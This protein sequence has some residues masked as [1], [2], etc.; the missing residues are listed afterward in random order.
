[1]NVTFRTA[2]LA[3]VLLL[4]CLGCVATK[5]AVSDQPGAGLISSWQPR[6]STAV[7]VRIPAPEEM[8]PT[9]TAW[10]RRANAQLASQNAWRLARIL[11]ECRLFQEVTVASAADI[12]TNALVIQAL[13]NEL[14]VADPNDP[15]LLLYG[16]VVPIYRCFDESVR[17]T[18]LQDSK[19]E[20][21]FPWKTQSLVG[22]WAPMVA[23][24]GSG[25][26][27][28]LTVQRPVSESQYWSALRLALIK[29]MERRSPDP[30][31]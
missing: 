24:A 25:W 5:N 12:A 4:P 29:E 10:E 21:V 26:H 11:A 17:F 30:A 27:L 28:S 8:G 20:F 9:T 14:P 7:C 31:R 3:I 19:T 1:M 2:G 13:P 18:F 23:A 15:W 16:G 6:Y 22:V